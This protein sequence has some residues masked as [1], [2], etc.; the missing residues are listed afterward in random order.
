MAGFEGSYLG[1]EERISDES[2]ME[3]KICWW[4]YDPSVGDDVWQI[5]AGTPFS[6]LP[7]HW[8]CPNCDGAKDQFMVTHA[9]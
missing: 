4:V 3:C 1:K 7:D 9:E 6:A 8:K 5:P 2:T